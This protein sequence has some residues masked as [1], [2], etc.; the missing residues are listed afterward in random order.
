M[1]YV[2]ITWR[3]VT[4]VEGLSVRLIRVCLQVCGTLLV[5]G[6]EVDFVDS[7]TSLVS[8]FCLQLDFAALT[9]PRILFGLELDD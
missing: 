1:G 8:E 2:D 4:E 6:I 7:M 3:L 5:S 9:W